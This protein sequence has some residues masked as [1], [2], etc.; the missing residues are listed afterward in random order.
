[1]GEQNSNVTSCGELFIQPACSL[2]EIL[3]V[4]T[5]FDLDFTLQIPQIQI[6]TILRNRKRRTRVELS[7]HRREVGRRRNRT[8]TVSCPAI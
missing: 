3:F 7:Q 4:R 8:W 5:V 1:M 2:R 6:K